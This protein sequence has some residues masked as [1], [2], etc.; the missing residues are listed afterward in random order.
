MISG[1]DDPALPHPDLRLLL[2]TSG[3]TGDPKL[4]RLSEDNMQ[5]NAASIV[6]YLRL[7]PTDRGMTTLPLHYSYGL[8]V[9]HSHLEAGAGLILT[10]TGVTDAA[11]DHLCR[12]ARVTNLAFVPHQL[13]LL[14]ARGA[15]LSGLPD[16]RF[17]T[18]AGGRLGAQKV[19]A[20]AQTGQANGWDFIVMYGQTEAAPRMAWLPPDKALR[21]RR[22]DRAG[23]PRRTLPDRGRERRPH[24]RPGPL[25]RACL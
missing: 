20:W 5:A 14:D 19:R 13:N 10:D 9:L 22:H 3:S 11:F 7:G 12:T 6:D 15:D 16:L 25:G 24:H 4:V 2:S 23:H 18:Q 1:A 17:V 21:C 8:S